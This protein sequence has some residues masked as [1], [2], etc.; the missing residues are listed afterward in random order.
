MNAEQYHPAL[1]PLEEACCLAETGWICLRNPLTGWGREGA[2][3][4]KAGVL[5]HHAGLVFRCWSAAANR[6]ILVREF[7]TL[8]LLMVFPLLWPLRKKTWFLIHH[9]LQ[10]A[11]RSR[12]EY[13]G[14]AVLS[15]LGV[16]WALLETQDFQG[17]GK[18]H[19]PAACNLI[20]PHPVS[21]AEPGGRQDRD[22]PVIGVA[23]YYRP[24]KGMD[25][26]L[27]LLVKHFPDCEIVA[28]VPNPEAVRAPS[29]TVLNTASDEDYRAMLARCDVLVFN[30]RESGY[31]YR[32]SGPVAD[33]AACG[34]SV[35][36]P[37]FPI[38][39]KQAA[40]IGEVFQ[41]LEKM[42][43]AVRCALGKVCAGRYDF[44]AYC[45]SRSARALAEKL[46]DFSRRAD[47]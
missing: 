14:M 5:L 4:W 46:D 26:L 40:G 35:V 21:A 42:P 13:F 44:A 28:G 9:N 27:R 36:V 37:D 12:V 6:H 2:R 20:L 45:V 32:A 8:P 47:G 41:T 39:G 3:R 7:S 17:F 33:A 38:L 29:V 10:W 22:R 31:F 19:I 25:E 15:R 1:R 16:R 34:T 24:E 30:Y 43:E 11:E 23:G 18:L